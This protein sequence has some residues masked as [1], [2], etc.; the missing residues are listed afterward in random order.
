MKYVLLAIFCSTF[1]LSGCI[2]IYFDITP[3]ADGTYRLKRTIVLGPDFMS[4]MQQIPTLKSNSS[5][6]DTKTIADSIMAEFKN[7]RGIYTKYSGVMSYNLRDSVAD[8]TALIITELQVRDANVMKRVGN[9]SFFSMKQQDSGA[10]NKTFQ[11][12]LSKAKGKTTMEFSFIP[13]TNI[14]SLSGEELATFNQFFSNHYIYIRLFSPDLIR[15]NPSKEI[16]E[17]PSGQQ[18]KVSYV[19]F[20]GITPKNPLKNKFLLRTAK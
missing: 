16:E 9:E 19:K 12:Q 7:E 10:T 20:P 13:E 8:S 14:K 2:D 6:Y 4:Q 11:M 3:L 18:W 17:I 1:F 5:W 15:P